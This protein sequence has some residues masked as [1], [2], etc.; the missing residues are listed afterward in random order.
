MNVNNSLYR[1]RILNSSNARIYRIALAKWKNGKIDTTNN[2]K[3]SKNFIQVGTEGGFFPDGKFPHIGN[4]SS[5]LTL[6]PAERADV[7]INFSAFE[8]GTSLVLL[9]YAAD[10][11]Y[12]DDYTIPIDTSGVFSDLTNYVML[13]HINQNNISSSTV[14]ESTLTDELNN[15]SSSPI[16]KQTTASEFLY[17]Y[18]DNNPQFKADLQKALE[19]K[20]N[21]GVNAQPAAKNAFASIFPKES[22]LF[23]NAALFKLKISE[24]ANYDELPVPFKKYVEHHPM[25]KKDLAFPM[26]FLN[27]TDWNLESHTA[28][29]NATE[30]FEK[31]VNNYTTEI[32]AIWNSSD[33]VHPIHIHLN[34]FRILSREQADDSGNPIPGTFILPEPNEMAWKDV[35][36]AKPGYITYLL[37][38]YI[39]NDSTQE[40]QFLYHCHITEHEDMS[41]MRRLV[42][43]PADT[44]PKFVLTSY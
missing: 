21:G 1:F 16:Y 9:N 38:Q 25:M 30:Q 19:A 17:S 10:E 41:M 4:D 15:F 43:K 3:L 37:H 42:V 2:T 31:V 27:E 23:S 13:F 12:G 28:N 29:P 20:Y 33:D 24:A 35:V 6:E 11:V 14:S 22:D 36:R 5:A 39:L 26:D 34:K 8:P 7:L 18:Y 40:G 44:G 32:W